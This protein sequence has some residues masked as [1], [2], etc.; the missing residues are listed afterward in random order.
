MMWSDLERNAGVG[1]RL[2]AKHAAAA[3][4]LQARKRILQAIDGLERI[5]LMH[6]EPDLCA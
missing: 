1:E 2:K 4:F 6:D 5:E 3:E